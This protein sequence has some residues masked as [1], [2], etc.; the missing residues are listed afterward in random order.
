MILRV[1]RG[2][3]ASDQATVE[4][5]LLAV[6]FSPA[7]GAL[8]CP[9]HVVERKHVHKPKGAKAGLVTLSGG[10]I[11]QVRVQQERLDRLLRSAR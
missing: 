6:H 5:A 11:L 1:E 2:R 3:P 9:V 7:R 10:R 8:R 4:A